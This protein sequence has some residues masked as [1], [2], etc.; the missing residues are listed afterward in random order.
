M[1]QDKTDKTPD[2]APEP[3]EWGIPNWRD[4]AAYS[5]AKTW[6]FE[7]WRWEFIR[8]R[9]DV[10]EH[11]DAQIEETLELRS[12]FSRERRKPDEP[13]FTA[14]VDVEL[15]KSIG[16]MS[17]PNPRISEQPHIVLWPTDADDNVGIKVGDQIGANDYRGTVGELLAMIGLTVAE[18]KKGIIGDTMECFPVSLEPDQAAI[19]F[20]MNKPLEPQLKRAREFLRFQYKRRGK[21]LQ[22]KRHPAKWQQY[23]RTLDA[24]ESGASWR[25]ISSLHPNT[26]Q[27]DQTARDI[28]NAASALRF[29]F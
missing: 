12:R 13:G 2:V 9:E 24:R 21:P 26:A 11:F 27:T 19:T 18:E 7:R 1:A 28:F 6:S 25:E 20:D 14:M 16:Y 4:P 23:L 22:R 10:R 5:D 29:N 15:Q 8:R 17:L 3:S